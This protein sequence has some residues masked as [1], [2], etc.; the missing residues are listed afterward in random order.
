MKT[1]KYLIAAAAFLLLA[2][3]SYRPHNL[4]NPEWTSK[5]ESF[6]VLYTDPYIINQSDL[7]DDLPEYKDN[8][9][10]WIEKEFSSHLSKLTGIQPQM[11]QISEDSLELH[12]LRYTQE[13][14]INAPFPKSKDN[15]QGVVFIIH[16]IRSNRKMDPCYKTHCGSLP[17]NRFILN[18][19]FTAL[20]ISR[21]EIL[22]YGDISNV[23]TFHFALTKSDWENAIKE[24]AERMIE[25]TPLIS[26]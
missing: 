6:T 25:G 18:G 3:C 15:L 17:N 24:M 26:E 13:T 9:A 11:R 5:P 20:D 14:L 8:I 10:Q 16:P 2:S 22:A 7:E 23:Q 21:N 12:P 19:V 4:V 1:L